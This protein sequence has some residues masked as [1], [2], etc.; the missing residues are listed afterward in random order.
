MAYYDQLIT[1]WATL[2]PGTTEAKLAEINSRARVLQEQKDMPQDEKQA[3][4][5]ALQ[6]QRV[7][8]LRTAN[9]AITDLEE[10]LRN[11]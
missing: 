6:Q 4:M 9:E 10:A 8:L 5:R 7:N 2:T 1:K 11:E 3:I